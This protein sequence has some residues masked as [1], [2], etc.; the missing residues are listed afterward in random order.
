MSRL[1]LKSKQYGESNT[2]TYLHGA[3]SPLLLYLND[4]WWTIQW[5][6]LYWLCIHLV[7]WVLEAHLYPCSLLEPSILTLCGELLDTTSKEIKFLRITFPH[8]KKLTTILQSIVNISQ[9]ESS[10]R[11]NRRNKKHALKINSIALEHSFLRWHSWNKI[12]QLLN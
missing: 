12:N 8:I 11:T 10:I 3:Y 9:N 7:F 2:Q 6:P 5:L 1:S 4:Q